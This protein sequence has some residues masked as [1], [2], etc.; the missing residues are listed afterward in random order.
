MMTGRRWVGHF[1]VTRRPS[2]KVDR[3]ATRGKG[4][5]EHGD[6]SFSLLF[7]PAGIKITLMQS[8]PGF[9][10]VRDPSEPVHVPRRP[11]RK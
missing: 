7:R 8:D 2:Q 5:D 3:A 11:G 4:F 1:Y 10:C 9:C 6:A